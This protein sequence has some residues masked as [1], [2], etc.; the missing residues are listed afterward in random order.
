[1]DGKFVSIVVYLGRFVFGFPNTNSGEVFKRECRAAF[2]LERQERI[3]RS[4]SCDHQEPSTKTR[5]RSDSSISFQREK[6]PKSLVGVRYDLPVPRP[7]RTAKG[8]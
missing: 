2:D 6:Q 5:T 1:M 7:R 8:R 4:A 3:G